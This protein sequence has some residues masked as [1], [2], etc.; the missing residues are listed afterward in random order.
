MVPAKREV[1]RAE[2]K[3]TKGDRKTADERSRRDP[4]AA[5]VDKLYLTNRAF[6]L[7]HQLIVKEK[8][9]RSGVVE[10]EAWIAGSHGESDMPVLRAVQSSGGIR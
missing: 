9:K 7:Q 8:R 6:E 5:L 1:A 2:R 3:A 10:S 4:Q